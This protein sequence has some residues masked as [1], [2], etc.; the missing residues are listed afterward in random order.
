MEDK[1]IAFKDFSRGYEQLTQREK[2]TFAK[3]S[4]RILNRSF[5]Q[6]A[7][8]DDLDYY[9]F[10][11]E[12]LDTLEAYFLMTDYQIN[13]YSQ[14]M[15]F[16]LK[17]LA[18]R[19]RYRL[20]KL[21]TLILL[22]LRQLYTIKSSEVTLDGNI[23]CSVSELHDS[24]R[25][26]N[27]VVDRIGKTELANSL[28]TLRRYSVI[29]Y[30]ISKINDDDSVIR[31]YPAIIYVVNINDM[32]TLKERLDKYKNRGEALEETDED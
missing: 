3:V 18:D 19:N 32:N 8:K 29:E 26:K 9:T 16:Q 15:V 23:F 30:N 27:L 22:V 17:T 5:I 28:R 31:I 25:N 7:K 20:K 2:D 13:Y 12:H 24:L 1:K 6:K 4:N 21:D 10:M 11:E 14:D